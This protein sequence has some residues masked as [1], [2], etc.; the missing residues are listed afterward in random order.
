MESCMPN[1][2]AV[3]LCLALVICVWNLLRTHLCSRFLHLPL[4]AKLL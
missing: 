1:L 3:L 2:S 4:L